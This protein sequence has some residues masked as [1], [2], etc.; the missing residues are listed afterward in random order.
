MSDVAAIELALRLDKY[1]DLAAVNS[2]GVF[3]V[4][5]YCLENTADEREQV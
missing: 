4:L 1:F 3:V 2:R 5:E